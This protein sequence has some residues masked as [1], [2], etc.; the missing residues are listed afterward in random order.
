[1]N[2]KAN[3]ICL[4][5][6]S[7]QMDFSIG[8]NACY[9]LSVILKCIIFC[10]M[11]KLYFESGLEEFANRAK[12][13]LPNADTINRRIKKK[14]KE[15]VI[16]EFMKTQD[17]ILSKLRKM[18]LLTHRATALIDIT[19]IPYWGDKND[20]GVVGTKKQKGT[21]YCHQYVTIH[22]L[23]KDVKVCIHALPVTVFSNRAKLVDELLKVA[24]QKVRIGAVLMDRGFANSK[25]IPVIE[26]H[27]LKYLA[28]ITKN[29]KIHRIIKDLYWNKRNFNCDEIN[30]YTFG[31]GVT[32]KLFFTLNKKKKASAKIGERYFSWCTNMDVKPQIRDIL[33]DVYGRRWNIENFYRDG[34]G[35]FLAK[36]KSKRFE[37]RLFFFLLSA[38][39]YNIW[40]LIKIIRRGVITA[41]KWKTSVYD[42]L[43]SKS[44]LWLETKRYEEKIWAGVIEGVF[45]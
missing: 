18:R 20:K 38:I 19:E 41:Q 1:M 8:A 10:A 27:E 26:K 32:T 44:K 43:Y 17:A 21:S 23:I 2:K 14:T 33:A 25:I 5:L 28:P 6:M 9:S 3:K 12:E 36:T 16:A 39:L 31:S 4:G 24:L 45:D 37:V 13:K 40:Q 35:N 22:A 42:L 7:K 29:D 11:R 15:K 34:K 30:N